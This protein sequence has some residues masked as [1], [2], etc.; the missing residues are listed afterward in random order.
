MTKGLSI[1]TENEK[2]QISNT[3]TP[4]DKQLWDIMF[5]Y[6]RPR[7]KLEERHE[8]S[9][10][11]LIRTWSPEKTEEDLKDAFRRLT[12][13]IKHVVKVSPRRKT[14][15]AFAP[16]PTVSIHDGICYYSYCTGLRQLVKPK[17]IAD[18]LAMLGITFDWSAKKDNCQAA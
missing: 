15:L 10:A 8:I 9:T 7:L 16:M 5:A 14:Y 2:I 1:V 4:E 18:S 17:S 12:F 3:I 6:A 13:N 11:E